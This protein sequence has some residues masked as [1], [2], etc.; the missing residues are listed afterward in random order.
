MAD[1]SV[2]APKAAQSKAGKPRKP[3][4]PAKAEPSMRRT[5]VT[6]EGVDL[7]VEIAPAGARAGAF[8][9]D[10]LI[11]IGIVV[12]LT[13]AASLALR[14]ESR[15]VIEIIWMLGFF[16]LRNFWFMGWEMQARGATPGKRIMKIRVAMRNGGRLTADAV[17]ARN[18][19]RELEVFLPLMLL[20]AGAFQFGPWGWV[21]GVVWSFIFL[22][23]PLF[24]RDKLRVGDLIAGTWV[25]QAPRMRLA[26]DL[27]SE[28]HERLAR[29]NFSPAQ[30]D[31]YGVMELQVLEDVLRRIEF[32]T[33][34]AVASR[35]R[36]K[37][38]WTASPDESDYDFLNAYYAALR[39]HLEQKLLFGKRKKD[40]HDRV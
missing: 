37:I 33:M 3:A 26:P 29:Y 7:G 17:F 20:I 2:K 35:I 36:A 38:G 12:G 25:V 31:A 21:A 8:I 19:V 23:F 18:A 13:I 9:L 22:L 16:L 1:L 34:A 10:G 39:K 6:P 4:R 14:K 15:D 11:L 32:K 24:N 27:A 40:K 28:A 30:L 5:L